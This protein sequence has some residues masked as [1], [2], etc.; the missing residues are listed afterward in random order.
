MLTVVASV[1]LAAPAS[2]AAP[3][4]NDQ[5][6][7]LITGETLDVFLDA[8]DDDGDDLSFT[9]VASPDHGVLDDCTF[10]SCTYTPDAGYVGEDSFTW[11][12]SDGVEDSN[13]A[14]FT[15]T[16]A[17]STSGNAITSSGPLTKVQISPYLNCAVNH[18]AD[19]EGEFYNDTACGTFAVVD[20]V[21]Y[22]PASI[23]AGTPGTPYTPVSQTGVTGAGTQ[24]SPYRIVTTVALGESGVQLV[25]TDSYVVGQESYRTDVVINNSAAARSVRLYRAGDCYLADSDDGLGTVGPNGAVACKSAAMGSNRIEQ[26]MPLSAG[27]RYYEA[28]YDEVWSLIAAKGQFPNTCRC[29]ENI[30]NGAG[31]QW[32]V[33]LAASASATRSSLI[34][35]SPVG[36]LPL[37]VGKVVDKPNA[38]FGETVGYTITVSNPGSTAA[39]LTEIADTLPAGFSYQSG[40]TTGVTTSNPVSAGGSLEWAVNVPVPAGGS[41]VLGFDA[42]TPATEGVFYNNASGE[43]A[44]LFVTPTGDTAPVSLSLEPVNNA[45]SAADDTLTTAEDTPAGVSVLTNDADP[46]AADTI[47]ITAETDGAHGTVACTSTTCTYTPV[48]DFHGMDAFSYTVTDSNGASD[49]AVVTVTVTAVNDAPNAVND[50]MST[51]SGVA[52]AK[53]VRANDTDVDG[54]PISISTPAPAAAHGTVTCSTLSC[55]YKSVA[56]YVGPDSFTYAVTDGHGGSDTAV[57]SVNVTAVADISV[58]MGRVVPAPGV[59][60]A[61]GYILSVKNVGT[62]TSGTVTLKDTLPASFRIRATP[63]GCTRS[64]QL[65]TCALGTF[66]GG[67]T[68]TVRVD[69]AFVNA[70]AIANTAQALVSPA[71]A[72]AGN[73]TVTSSTTVSGVTCTRVGTFAADTL[74]GTTGNDVICGLAGNDTLKG[75]AGVDRVLGNEGND[76]IDGGAGN[77]TLEGGAGVDLVAYDS[78]TSAVTAKLASFQATGGGG[79]DVLR[80]LENVRGSA[81]ADLLYGDGLANLLSGMGGA[82]KLYGLGGNDNLQGGDGNDRLEGGTGT[83]TLNGGAGTNVLIQ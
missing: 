24:A 18:T 27:S 69:G 13:V 72:F 44:G 37:H 76:T 65:I 7:A 4:A 66:A 59:G 80:G 42:T 8:F 30:D 33:P 58:T 34:T 71:D 19:T 22:S 46:D 51:G 26:F 40:S 64:G 35:F 38:T 55:T 31:L 23:P 49:T 32:D 20:D 15:I 52:T 54:D 83:D 47:T 39:T 56:G 16:V 73:N 63:A 11:K 10:G 62:L 2:A 57:V 29:A 60:N 74:T 21:M 28:E 48:P 79:T 81:F 9:I 78:A 12:A 70:G 41:V 61:A 25:Q 36:S 17:P 82:D 5:Q 77:D 68:K 50:T 67:I 43:A 6:G 3:V 53:A 14:T 45:P 1:L 75:V